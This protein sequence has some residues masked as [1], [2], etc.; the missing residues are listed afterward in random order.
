MTAEE[1]APVLAIL[2]H[3]NEGKSSVVSTLAEDDQVPISSTPGETR[4][5]REYPVEID[6]RVVIRFVDTPGFQRPRDTLKWLTA[7]TGPADRMLSEFIRIHCTDAEFAD[8]CELLTPLAHGAGVIF[9]VDGSRPVRR[10]DRMEMEILR[11]TGLPR[12][13][14]INTKDRALSEYLQDWKSQSRRHFNTIQIFDAQRASF[15]E[16]IALL[17]SLKGID[18]D[19][20][21]ALKNVIDSF[22]ADWQQR[23]TETAGIIED[24]LVSA[25]THRVQKT[26]RD[27]GRIEQVRTELAR[28]YQKDIARFE[29][30]AHQRIRK[31]F[32]HNIF[33]YE[34]PAQSIVKEDLFSS[35]TW[36]VLGLTRRQL[37]WAGAGIGAGIGANVDIALG[38]LTF[39]VFTAIG[40]VMGAGSAAAGTRKMAKSKIKGQAL[41]GARL[42]VG[43]VENDPLL[44]VI[45]DRAL[46]YFSH[47]INWAHSRRNSA[48]EEDFAD[49]DIKA[50]LTSNWDDSARKTA[51]RFFR[52]VRKADAD[53]SDTAPK[54]FRKKLIEVLRG[55]SDLEE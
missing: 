24:L 26:C 32:K 47:V 17:E 46:I 13:I 34:L 16:R 23:I 1:Q 52:A 54:A 20:Q 49:I 10:T 36:Q 25:A 4:Q 14:V 35:K 38:G 53:G 3:P 37:A 45:I 48:G 5:C 21:P 43:P 7:Y 28:Q 30:R 18:P 22:A 6:G 31:R 12:M 15:A 19:W 27:P 29:A 2:G 33:S 55:L 42:Q 44:F 8:E 50:F 40:G 41:G 51:R 9:V 11:L 39:G